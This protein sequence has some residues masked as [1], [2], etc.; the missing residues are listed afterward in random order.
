MAPAQPFMDSDLDIKPHI[1]EKMAPASS[2]TNL[3]GKGLRCRSICQD[4]NTAA[5]AMLDDQTKAP[6]CPE[7]LD[8]DIT[9]C[10]V[11]SDIRLPKSE[12]P[13]ATEYSSSFADTLSNTENCSGLSEGEVE[14]QFFGDN[15]LAPPFDAFSGAI[16]V[17]KKK[18]TNHWRNFIRPLMWRCK[19]TELRIKELESRALKYC[20]ESETYD[21]RK[22]LGFNQFMFEELGSK[23]LPFSRQCY[24]NKAVKRRKRKRVEDTTDI[25]S[26]MSQHNLFSYLE[27]K[28]SDPDGSLGAD[29]FGPPV[30]TDQNGN[31]NDKFGNGSDWSFFELKDG[32]HFLEQV[33]WKI[34]MVHSRVHKLKG[35]ID[36][37]LSKNAARFSSSE[38]LSLLAPCDGQTSSAHSPTCSAGNGETVSV[39]HVYSP[40][41]HMS[42]FDNVDLVMPGSAV[43]CDRAGLS[44]TRG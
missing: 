40:P 12:D 1:A 24:K 25:T 15:S 9:G 13:D 18:L 30:I 26:Y 36:I 42:E 32:E 27:I 31:C 44:I 23:S 22:Q 34:E 38:N 29:D 21:Q 5:Q 37:I 11:R 28:K 39:G 41:K 16:Q 20:R 7:D 2:V 19:W 6:K 35:Q 10:T 33:L 43:D 14:S 8:V 17:R 4:T 3:D